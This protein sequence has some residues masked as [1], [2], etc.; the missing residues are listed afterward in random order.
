MSFILLSYLKEFLVK[1]CIRRAALNGKE[2][3]DEPAA[4]QLEVYH[5]TFCESHL[6]V[7]YSS[8]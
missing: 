8:L 6:I 3:A 2:L 4:L 5:R 1:P 7:L